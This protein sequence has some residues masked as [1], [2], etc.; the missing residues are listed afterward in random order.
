[1]NRRGGEAVASAA[2]P[3]LAEI[4]RDEGFSSAS[5]CL[6]NKQREDGVAVEER[7]WA[8]EERSWAV[9]GAYRW[10]VWASEPS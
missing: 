5:R 7:S 2:A 10:A 3:I 4:W 1:M 9:G 6:W 8:V